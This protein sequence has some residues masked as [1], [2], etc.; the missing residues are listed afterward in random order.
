[1]FADE[2]WYKKD[3]QEANVAEESDAKAV[4]MMATIGDESE[5]SEEWFLDSGCSNHMTPHREWFISFDASKKTNIKLA[6]SRKLA[7][8]GTSNIVIRGKTG[9]K[10]ILKM[11]FMFLR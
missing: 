11:Y 9:N 7:A 10:V 3:Q 4:L 2:C 8:E 5:K 6:D 1:H